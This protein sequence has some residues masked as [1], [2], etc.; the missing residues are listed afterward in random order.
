ME[1][2]NDDEMDS[3][4]YYAEWDKAEWEQSTKTNVISVSGVLRSYFG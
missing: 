1:S 4:L 3:A 2:E